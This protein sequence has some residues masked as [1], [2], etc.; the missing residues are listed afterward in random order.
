MKLCYAFVK[1][2][3]KVTNVVVIRFK[4]EHYCSVGYTQLLKM[5]YIER[6][7]HANT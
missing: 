6:S 7:K 2:E 5:H 3:F 1:S 4:V